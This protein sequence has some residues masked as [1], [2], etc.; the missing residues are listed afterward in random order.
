MATEVKLIA[1]GAVSAS[2]LTL[3]TASAGT[4]DTSP[5]TTAFVQQEITGLID[6]A[7]D[8]MN[9]LNELAAAL[10]DDANFSTTVTNSIAT[11]LPLAGGT[12]TG[13]LLLNQSTSLIGTNTSDGSDNKSVMLN[14]GGSA[15]DSRGAYVWAKGNEFSSEGGFLRL[16]AGNVS[17][18]AVVI[19]TAGSER[20]RI[21]SS[22]N[23]GIATSSPANKL[24]VSGNVY[25]AG[26]NTFTDSTS[27]Y[28]FGGNGSFT[29]GVYGVGT[30]NMAFNVNGSERMRIDSSGNVDVNTGRIKVINSGTDAYF[31]EGVRSGGNTTLRMYDNNNNLYID[32]YTN[33]TLRCNQTGGGSGGHIYLS[34]GNVGI[35][36]SGAPSASIDVRRNTNTVNN[37]D[38]LGFDVVGNI[39][40]AANNPG[41]HYTSGLRLYQG[42]GTVG[43]GLGVMY[44]G[45][46]NGNATPENDYTGQ[47]TAPDGMSGGLRL[48]TFHNDA[49]IRFYT[50]HSSTIALRMD[51]DNEGI[52]VQ[53]I[54]L[55]ASANASLTTTATDFY[56]NSTGAITTGTYILRIILQGGGWYSETHTG[57]MRWY[58]GTTN[59]PSANTIYLTGMGHANTIGTLNARVLR[60]YSNT[61]THSIQLWLSSG[62]SSNHTITMQAAKIQD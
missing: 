43:S 46:D 36:V 50:K 45:A 47:I 33:M 22:G 4:N 7:P 16:H 60:K 37:L 9:T 23:V 17:G 53:G 5:A 56:V 29:N 44:L 54:D 15:S 14:G 58:S 12:M 26:A 31:Y 41:N 39:G 59:N 40:N 49:K 13:N 51:I 38:S 42:S 1:T 34:G 10:G 35:N 30:N 6:S 27:G 21:D 18:G 2:D 11:K 57:I 32:S 62:S 20:M 61:N 28:F 55:Y 8:A 3:T 25:I 52:D 48:N 24:H 19:N